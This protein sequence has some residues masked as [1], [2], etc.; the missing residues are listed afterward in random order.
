LAPL[1][2]V[3]AASHAPISP[4]PYGDESPEFVVVGEVPGCVAVG[5]VLEV[6]AMGYAPASPVLAQVA[7]L[8]H[9]LPW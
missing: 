2:E 9:H 8:A 4:A 7:R 6:L 5:Q 1:G 3:F